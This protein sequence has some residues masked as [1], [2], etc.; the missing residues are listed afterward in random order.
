MDALNRG[1]R[2]DWRD[3]NR[4]RLLVDGDAFFPAMLAAIGQARAYVLLEMY[5]C[6]SGEVTDRFIEALIDARRRGIA[7]YLLL[8]H[9]GAAGLSRHDRHRLNRAGVDLRFFNPIDYGR[10]RANLFRDH[11]KLL[12]VDGRVAFVGGAGL[13]DEFGDG[14]QR[15]WHEVMTE[16]RGPCVTDWVD[17]F[18][19]NRDNWADRPM[20]LPLP[21]A[22]PL[23]EGHPGRV[24]INAPTRMEIKRSLL[25]RLRTAE[26]R[27][28]IAVAYFIPS[29]KFRRELRRAARRGVDVRLLLP[30]P[31]TDLPPVRHAG[32]RFYARLLRHDV[33]IFEYQPR[34]LHAKVLLCDD[35]VSVGS[36]NIDRWNLS[37]NLEANQESADPQLRAAVERMF[38]TDFEQSREYLKEV[39]CARPW[40]RRLL[41]RF[42]GWV[43]VW[44]ERRT[45][46]RR[47][48][49]LSRRKD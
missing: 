41:E 9:F 27:V 42:W 43:D 19:Q 23:R 36:S 17:V 13:T 20:G 10:L 37:W 22:K 25:K 47:R 28:W 7:V 38:E 33:R 12:V 24:V 26:R 29:R 45:E 34:F 15:M 6:E 21:E 35:W 8:D 31:Y 18:R 48:R 44:M 1:Y 4:F 11:R 30:G 16:V 14:A 3:G 2:F 40:Y 32:R 39:W 5:L 46:S 49:D